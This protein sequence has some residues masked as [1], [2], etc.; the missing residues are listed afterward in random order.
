MVQTVNTRMAW[1]PQFAPVTIEEPPA[2]GPLVRDNPLS[3]TR[4]GFGKRNI[5]APPSVQR[6]LRIQEFFTCSLMQI[7]SHNNSELG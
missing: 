3:I 2:W 5:Y 6:F 1:M 7:F 4:T